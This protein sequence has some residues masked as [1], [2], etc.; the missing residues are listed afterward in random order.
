MITLFYALDGT[1]KLLG[2]RFFWC[3]IVMLFVLILWFY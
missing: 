2:F 3:L 1:E